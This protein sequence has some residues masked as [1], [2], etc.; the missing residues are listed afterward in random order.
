[1]LYDF[2]YNAV[3]LVGGPTDR[4]LAKPGWRTTGAGWRADVDVDQEKGQMRGSPPSPAARCAKT[5]AMARRCW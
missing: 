2:S 4:K 3:T 5:A 1:L